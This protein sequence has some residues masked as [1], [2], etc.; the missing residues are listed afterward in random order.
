MQRLRAW[1]L[2]SLLF[3][4]MILLTGIAVQKSSARL[5]PDRNSNLMDARISQQIELSLPD[6]QTLPPYD[7]RL[8][9]NQNAGRMWI[10]FS[11][12]ILN[13]GPGVLEL[14]GERDR[15]SGD[16][17]VHQN[18]YFS[19]DQFV[20]NSLG[21]FEF[22]ESHN[23]WH[24]ESFSLYEVRRVGSGGEP[25]EVVASSGKVSYCVRDT[26]PA[27]VLDPNLP[28]PANAAE[29][30]RYTACGWTLQGLSPGWVDTYWHN[31]P[32]QFV[33]I[34]G[35]P[36]GRYLLVSTVDPENLLLETDEGNNTASLYFTLID[37]KLVMGDG[38][39]LTSQAGEQLLNSSCRA[40]N[41]LRHPSGLGP[42]IR[43]LN[44]SLPCRY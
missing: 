33:D 3:F 1:R 23:H 39:V 36:N 41:E 21:L 27:G 43:R 26:D 25:L 31:T 22:E 17:L 37:D 40:G 19:K 18:I 29:Q 8:I 9:L 13:S 32:G 6:L 15:K 38:E 35:L 24:Y 20:Q 2:A 10:R 7:L 14:A 12:S 11:N 34:S 30:A 28:V 5:L 16:I 44:I 4:L 42:R